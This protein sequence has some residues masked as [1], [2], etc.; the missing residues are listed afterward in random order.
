MRLLSVSFMESVIAS[1]MPS[2]PLMMTV[3]STGL[4]VL[5]SFI[6]DS[7]SMADA[8]MYSSMFFIVW[9][10][11]FWF[12]SMTTSSGDSTFTASSFICIIIRKESSW[13]LTTDGMSST[14]LISANG[15]FPAMAAFFFV[16]GMSI[17]IFTPLS[18]VS[19]NSGLRYL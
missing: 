8:H 13:Q 19:R 11:D 17:L 1:Y 9:T 2:S 16:M 4:P 14:C 6:L 15:I 18:A 7:K 5:I 3:L 12:V 10:V